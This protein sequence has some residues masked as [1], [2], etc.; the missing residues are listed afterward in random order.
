M[1]IKFEIR[2]FWGSDGD[3]DDDNGEDDMFLRHVGISLRVYT[4]TK[5][6]TTSW[7]WIKFCIFA[8][9]YLQYKLHSI[10]GYYLNVQRSDNTYWQGDSKLQPREP[11][12]QLK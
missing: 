10:M 12:Q 1:L 6:R 8:K 9:K 5:P 11:M 3:D 2:G 7:M 4:T